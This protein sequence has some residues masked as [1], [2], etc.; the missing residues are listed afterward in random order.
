MP[1]VRRVANAAGAAFGLTGYV[2]MV[3]ISVAV[4]EH[5]VLR[6]IGFAD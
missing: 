6:C 1:A 2:Q 5:G 4:S 3:Q